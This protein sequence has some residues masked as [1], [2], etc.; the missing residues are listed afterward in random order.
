MHDIIAGRLAMLESRLA[1]IE[2][3]ADDVRER[4]K[5]LENN[6]RWRD[7][8]FYILVLTIIVG[9]VLTNVHLFTVVGK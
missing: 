9:I 8:Q 3:K 2:S 6:A 1:V 5:T 4:V 7:R